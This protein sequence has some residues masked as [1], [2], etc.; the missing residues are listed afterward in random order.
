M[1]ISTI[2]TTKTSEITIIMEKGKKGKRKRDV[3]RKEEV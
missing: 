2:E 1:S 3:K